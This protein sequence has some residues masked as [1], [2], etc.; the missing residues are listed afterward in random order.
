M[1]YF[2]GMAIAALAIIRLARGGADAAALAD[3]VVEHG[4]HVADPQAL[5]PALALGAFVYAELGAPERARP[6]LDE[7][8]PMPFI[9]AVPDALFAAARL[10]ANDD[11]AAR[12]RACRRKTPFDAAA[13]AVLAGR[14]IDAADVYDEMGARPYAALASLRAAEVLVAEGR[15]AEADEQ[16]ARALAF[17]RSVGATRYVREGEA[18]LAATA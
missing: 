3:Q 6:L 11:W 2:D 7:I 15:R 9:A 16:L 10:G 12:T 17:W 8:E 5:I 4:R 13:D 1:H 14:W 18:L